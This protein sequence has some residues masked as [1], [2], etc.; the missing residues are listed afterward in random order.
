MSEPKI[1]RALASALHQAITEL[2]PTRLEFYESW[3]TPARIRGGELGRARVTAVISF[4]RQEGDVYQAVMAHAGQHTA[5]W[6]LATVGALR[7]ALITRLPRPLRLRAVLRLTNRLIQGLHDDGRL[8]ATVRR[9]RAVVTLEGSLF[10]DVRERAGGPLCRFY[11]AMLE[12]C[13]AA[14]DLHGRAEIA[15]CRGAGDPVCE[16]IIDTCDDA[17]PGDTGPADTGRD[18]S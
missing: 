10:C 7:R 3:L 11:G 16:L 2:M 4:L 12:H 15:R 6:T 5:D 14:F 9:G 13:L 18:S 8:E 1:G 17:E